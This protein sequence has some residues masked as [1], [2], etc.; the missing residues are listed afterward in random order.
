MK[1]LDKEAGNIMRQ[2][3][4]LPENQITLKV[5]GHSHRLSDFEAKMPKLELH[6]QLSLMCVCVR[7]TTLGSRG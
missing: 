1:P 2:T 5:E 7:I 6:D 4:T 3:H